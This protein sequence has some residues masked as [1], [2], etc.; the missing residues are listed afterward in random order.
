M[1]TKS[2]SSSSGRGWAAPAVAI[3]LI[4]AALYFGRTVFAPVAMALFIIALIWPLQQRL[5]RHMPGLLA[6]FL[7]L[8]ITILAVVAVAASLVWGFGVVAQWLIQNAARFQAMYDSLTEWLEGHGIMLMEPV[9]ERFNTAWLIRFLQSIALSANSMVGFAV[10]VFVFVMLGL[11]EVKVAARQLDALPGGGSQ[12]WSATGR[13]VA[14]KFRRYMLVRTA[15]SLM[16]GLAVWLFSLSV[17]LELATAWGFIAFALNYIPFLGPFI[18]TILPALFAIAQFESWQMA[19]LVFG[20]LTL[21]QFVIGSYLEP[22]F[23][24]SALSVSPFAVVL[25]VFFWSLLWGLTGA[26]IGVPI[27]IALT[28]ICE[29][30]QSAKWFATLLA[31]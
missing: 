29:K 23:A 18:A 11:L 21:A 9:S 14:K 19:L 4:I 27:L 1:D 2:L 17:G 25:A 30:T 24:G 31:R 7:T 15:M 26:F 12:K 28:T 13:E 20:G 10:V 5:E 3:I 6:L 8:A 16:T 22:L